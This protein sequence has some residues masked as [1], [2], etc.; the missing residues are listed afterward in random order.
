MALP[1]EPLDDVLPI[2]AIVVVAEVTRVDDLEAWPADSKGPPD[3][4][5]PRPAQ[6]V[7]LRVTRVM[8]GASTA[9]GELTAR[10]PSGAYALQP[11]ARGAFLLD[12]SRGEPSILGRYG[13][14]TY[15]IE[16][17]EAALSR[18]TQSTP[19]GVQ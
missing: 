19:E 2:A 7:Q 16:E 17:I 11:G 5:A 8:R 14:D 10:K 9:N 6:R 18:P 4:A 15:A 3:S 12:T 1:P 13:P